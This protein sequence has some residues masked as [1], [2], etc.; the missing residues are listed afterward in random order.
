M[1]RA[2]AALADC[3]AVLAFVG[4]GRSTHDHGVSLPGMASTAWP[5]LVGLA[6][7]V[8][9]SSRRPSPPRRLLGDGARCALA[10]V[11]VGMA[12][13][14]VAGQGIAVAFVLVALVFLGAAMLGWRLAVLGVRA[15]GA[16]P[17]ATRRRA[18]GR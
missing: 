6:V 15:A 18:G 17:A 7:G 16:R 12:L 4:I 2:R 3:V 14:V 11:A 5:F 1:G 9:V 10:T 8:L 13:R